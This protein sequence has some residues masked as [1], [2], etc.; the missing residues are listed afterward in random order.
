MGVWW[1]MAIAKGYRVTDDIILSS[2]FVV[3]RQVDALTPPR[4]SAG[5]WL[6][7]EW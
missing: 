2:A 3:L 1:D 7:D 4:E 5:V 6:N